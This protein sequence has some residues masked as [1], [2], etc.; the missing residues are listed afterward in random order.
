MAKV[1]LRLLA[2]DYFLHPLLATKAG[3]R[4]VQFYLNVLLQSR[5]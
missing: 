2:N 4:M 1:E 5:A 3:K